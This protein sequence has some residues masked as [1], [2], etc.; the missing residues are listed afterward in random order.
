MTD[1]LSCGVP[2]THTRL[3]VSFGS[4][5]GELVIFMSF[6]VLFGPSNQRLFKSL[7]STLRL[8]TLHTLIGCFCFAQEPATIGVWSPRMGR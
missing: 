3:G 6:L 4:L 1:W 7:E 5:L 2:S 8:T